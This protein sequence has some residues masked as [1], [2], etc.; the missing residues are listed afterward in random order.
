M[1]S[2]L[3]DAFLLGPI[4]EPALVVRMAGFAGAIGL[5]GD[6]VEVKDLLRPLAKTRAAVVSDGREIREP[7]V[8]AGAD[9]DPFRDAVKLRRVTPTASTDLPVEDRQPTPIDGRVALELEGKV[10]V[11]GIAWSR[12]TDLWRGRKGLSGLGRS[13]KTAPAV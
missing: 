1:E 13:N 3:A 6:H 8:E 2:W 9:V 5:G 10:F 12:G 11:E 4:A 7:S